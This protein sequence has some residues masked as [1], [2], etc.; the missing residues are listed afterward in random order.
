MSGGIN[1]STH[2]SFFK[3]L[4]HHGHLI[5]LISFGN[6]FYL[7]ILGRLY[8]KILHRTLSFDPEVII[9]LFVIWCK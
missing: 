5:L 9:Y 2:V 4:H 8:F 1:P 6:C 7:N 3:W